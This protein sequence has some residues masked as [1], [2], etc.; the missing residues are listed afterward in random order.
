MTQ[1]MMPLEMK[2]RMKKGKTDIQSHTLFHNLNLMTNIAPHTVK[3]WCRRCLMNWGW[4]LQMRYIVCVCVCVW[5]GRGRGGG[6]V[7][8]CI[9]DRG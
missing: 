6:S 3:L 7:K 9:Y 2:M 8:V 1:L 5:E 4:N